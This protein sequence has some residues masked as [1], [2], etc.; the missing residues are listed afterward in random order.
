MIGKDLLCGLRLEMKALGVYVPK[1]VKTNVEAQPPAAVEGAKPQARED[2]A[3]QSEV[4][5]AP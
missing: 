2:T 1:P 4:V 5:S 3:A